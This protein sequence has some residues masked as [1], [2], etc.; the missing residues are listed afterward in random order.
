MS[1]PRRTNCEIVIGTTV[2]DAWA[3]WFDDFEIRPQG[4]TSR[5]IGTIVDQTALHG[6]LGRLRDLGIPILDVHITPLST[7]AHEHGAAGT[8]PHRRRA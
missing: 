3:D 7:I 4:A 6:I 2:G 5:L 1:N 8:S